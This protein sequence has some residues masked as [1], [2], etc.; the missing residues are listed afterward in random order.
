MSASPGELIP[1]AGVTT[2]P[3]CA[4][5]L[6]RGEGIPWPRAGTAHP[7][8]IAPKPEEMTAQPEPLVPRPA[9]ITAGPEE[10]TA[11]PRE[12]IAQAKQDTPGRR[13][14]VPRRDALVPFSGA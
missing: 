4:I 9:E 3:T 6:P 1:P 11:R 12:I 7:D 5:A 10:L 8:A 14:R 13:A 2:A